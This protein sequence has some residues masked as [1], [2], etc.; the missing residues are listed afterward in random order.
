MELRTKILEMMGG[1]EV[2]LEDIWFP[3]ET[4]LCAYEL[5]ANGR[6]D[7]V[8]RRKGK[9]LG[10]M[11]PA[12]SFGSKIHFAQGVSAGSTI[13]KSGDTERTPPFAAQIRQMINATN[14]QRMM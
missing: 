12:L 2:T 9:R 14:Y 3:D 4:S 10:A 1:G 13:S 6:N 11:P 7:A 8:R 5:V